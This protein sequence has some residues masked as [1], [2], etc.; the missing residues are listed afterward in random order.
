M[1]RGDTNLGT[2]W[3]VETRTQAPAIALRHTSDYGSGLWP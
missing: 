1:V 3:F 2:R